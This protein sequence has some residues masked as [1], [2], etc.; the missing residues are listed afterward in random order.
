MIDSSSEVAFMANDI[1]VYITHLVPHKSPQ[2]SQHE[3]EEMEDQL[4]P[5]TEN[6]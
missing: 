4:H 3:A 2:G 5:A 1:G 6:L